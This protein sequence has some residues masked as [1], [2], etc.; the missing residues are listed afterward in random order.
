MAA[1]TLSAIIFCVR[2]VFIVLHHING[3]AGFC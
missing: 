3:C 2:F 1:A